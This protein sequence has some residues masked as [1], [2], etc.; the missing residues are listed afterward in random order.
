VTTPTDDLA[1]LSARVA[2]LEQQNGWLKRG[3][4]LALVLAGTALLMGSQA[5]PKAKTLDVERLV[6]RDSFGRQRAAL[7]MTNVPADPSAALVLYDENERPRAGLGVNK[8]GPG[9]YFT[10]P[11]GKHRAVLSRNND[12]IGFVLLDDEGRART[13]FRVTDK[14]A[15]FAVHDEDGNR[16][17]ALIMDQDVPSL[18]LYDANG[19]ARGALRVEKKGAVFRLLDAKE[20]PVYT[21]TK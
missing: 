17:A 16:R 3:G 18:I 5:E 8:D 1:K 2:D 9:L 6:L 12:G 20:R 7:Q 14:G 10:D 13:E 4:A 19:K 11:N 15:G 21:L